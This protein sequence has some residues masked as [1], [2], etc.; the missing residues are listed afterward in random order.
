[1]RTVIQNFIKRMIKI[2]IY[3]TIQTN[4]LE[5]ND[6]LFVNKNNIYASIDDWTGAK[7]KI[8]AFHLYTWRIFFE[9]LLNQPEI[10]LYLPFSDGNPFW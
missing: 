8:F 3:V 10:R 6:C 4:Y 2:Y 5:Y 9:I 7:R 1:M